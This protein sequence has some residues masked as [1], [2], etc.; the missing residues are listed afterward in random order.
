MKQKPKIIKS[1]EN[2]TEDLQMQIKLAYPKG[3][4]RHLVSFVNKTGERQKGL[5][6]ETEEA[7]YLIKMTQQT[8]QAIVDE[9]DDFDDDG[10]LKARVRE[11]YMDGEEE[12]SLNFMDME[13]AEDPDFDLDI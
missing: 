4:A 3:Y 6:F 10:N 11:K 7:Y 9:D 13:I 5:P 2:L 1:Y 8:A 12:E